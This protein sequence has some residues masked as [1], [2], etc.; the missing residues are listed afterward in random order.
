M[1]GQALYPDSTGKGLEQLARQGKQKLSAIAL[2]D[3]RAD[4]IA[5]SSRD[6]LDQNGA[7]K[8]PIRSPEENGA[9][10]G[11]TLYAESTGKPTL[12]L[13]D[14]VLAREKRAEIAA[15]PETPDVNG[16]PQPTPPQP[17]EQPPQQPLTR[18]Q[19]LKARADRENQQLAAKQ[20][21]KTK[22]A[23]DRQDRVDALS[24]VDLRRAARHGLQRTEE[25]VEARENA[26]DA[27]IGRLYY[28]ESTGK[29][30]V[31]EARRNDRH[32]DRTQ[33]DGGKSEMEKLFDDIFSGTQQSDKDVASNVIGAG[34]AAGRA[35]KPKE[36]KD[37]IS[38]LTDK[39]K[40]FLKD[41]LRA[42]AVEQ[43]AK[44]GISI[45]KALA[46]QLERFQTTTQSIEKV[47]PPIV[48]D[49]IR[50]A[51]E[52]GKTLDALANDQALKETGKQITQLDPKI[53]TKMRV[54]ALYEVADTSVDAF[55]HI[56]RLAKAGG[57]LTVLSIGMAAESIASADDKVK[58]SA[59]QGLGLVAGAAITAGA[60]AL[61]GGLAL[62]LA[63]LIIG[64]A[65][66]AAGTAIDTYFDEAW[67]AVTGN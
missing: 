10:I 13:A 23:Q 7:N 8:A 59:K 61:T 25:R 38:N 18:Q 45:D 67:D 16:A 62:P 42:K 21:E 66:Y 44:E 33:P 3:K 43:A 31:S 11:K 64:G 51:A 37:L 30:A 4:D 56:Q 65:N 35:V 48:R 40:E 63:I 53:Q 46:N 27:E 26:R 49:I 24:P 12:P 52:K 47:A 20:A 17:P 54:K 29:E 58:E 32:G 50:N 55:K 15:Q 36:L 34:S 60:V 22:A 6:S 28:S 1:I 2:A 14:K 9:V 19:K 57:V 39:S 41:Q 5:P